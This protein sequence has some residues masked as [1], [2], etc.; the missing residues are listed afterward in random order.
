MCACMYLR[1]ISRG[2]LEVTNDWNSNRCKELIKKA[3]R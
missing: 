1:M 2:S 3:A